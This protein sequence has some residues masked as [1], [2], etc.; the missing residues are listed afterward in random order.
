MKHSTGPDN[1]KQLAED[2]LQRPDG[3]AVASEVEGT[4]DGQALTKTNATDQSYNRYTATMRSKSGLRAP[5]P[6]IPP[7]RGTRPS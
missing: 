1:V 4:H 7:S 5:H 6:T 3:E 2:L